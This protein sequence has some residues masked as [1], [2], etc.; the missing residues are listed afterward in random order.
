MHRKLTVSGEERAAEKAA[1]NRIRG[2]W[3]GPGHSPQKVGLSK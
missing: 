2:R 1:I 3:S